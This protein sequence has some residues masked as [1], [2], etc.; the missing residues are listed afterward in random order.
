MRPRQAARLDDR[1]AALA[2]GRDEHVRVPVGVV[3]PVLQR[4]AVDGGEAVIRVHRRRMVA[5]HHQLLDAGD[6]DAGLDRQLRQRAVV[7]QAQHRGEVLR[8]QVEGADF[9]AM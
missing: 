9:I 6:G 7:V 2:D 1:R 5:P 3:D 8:R 4:L